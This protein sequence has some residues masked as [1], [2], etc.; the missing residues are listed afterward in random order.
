MKDTYY[1]LC[2]DYVHSISFAEML[3]RFI[4]SAPN[5]IAEENRL[6]F[7]NHMVKYFE[8]Y[9]YEKYVRT[10]ADLDTSLSILKHLKLFLNSSGNDV[11]LVRV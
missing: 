1:I 7:R 9:K 11:E 6:K 5:F 10:K 2:N 3:Q 4:N 8:N